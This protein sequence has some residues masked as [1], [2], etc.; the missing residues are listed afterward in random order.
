MKKR[1]NKLV[2]LYKEYHNLEEIFIK[3]LAKSFGLLYEDVVDIVFEY[4]GDKESYESLI[5]Y[6]RDKYEKKN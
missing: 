5:K 3:D 2:K 4:I 1:Y 6:L